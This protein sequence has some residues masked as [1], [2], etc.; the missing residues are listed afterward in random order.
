M[1]SKKYIVMVDDNFH[2]MDSSERYKHGEYRTMQEAISTCKKIVDESLADNYKAGM[3]PKQLYASYC[4]FGE[5]PY[6]DS[7]EKS[8]FSAWDYALGQSKIIAV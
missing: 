7:N 1:N 4:M 3:S 6:V 5:D 8:N 2:F